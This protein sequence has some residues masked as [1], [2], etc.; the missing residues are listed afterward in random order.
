MSTVAKPVADLTP[1]ARLMLRGVFLVLRK[2]LPKHVRRRQSKDDFVHGCEQLLEK[3][4]IELVHDED[5]DTI[6]AKLP[7]GLEWQLLQ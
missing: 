1:S 6:Y 5:T 7:D 4:F 2:Q 3:G